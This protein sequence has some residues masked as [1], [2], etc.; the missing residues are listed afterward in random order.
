MS[1]IELF[2]SYA[3]EDQLLAKR[4]FDTLAAMPEVRIWM[5]KETLLPGEE[6]EQNIYEAI[7]RSRFFIVLLS[8]NWVRKDGFVKTE[9]QRLTELI[10]AAPSG[11]YTPIP[12]RL[13]PCFTDHPLLLR[14]QSVDMFPDWDRGALAIR[15]AIRK[16][17]D[18][19]TEAA[20]DQLVKGAYSPKAWTEEYA[21]HLLNLPSESVIELL[22]RKYNTLADD[23]FAVETL[24]QLAASAKSSMVSDYV[25]RTFEIVRMCGTEHELPSFYGSLLSCA[26]LL[27]KRLKPLFLRD[28]FNYRIEHLG[29][30]DRGSWWADLTLRDLAKHYICCESSWLLSHLTM[31]RQWHQK[32]LDVDQITVKK[33]LNQMEWD[34]AI[35]DLLVFYARRK[36]ETQILYTVLHLLRTSC[37]RAKG[38]GGLSSQRKLNFTA[39]PAGTQDSGWTREALRSDR[40]Q[41]A[42]DRAH[43]SRVGLLL[44]IAR[45]LAHSDPDYAAILWAE[46]L[47]GLEEVV[48][49]IA[50]RL[51][52]MS[53]SDLNA[54][55]DAI[56]RQDNH[57]IEFF[58]ESSK[59]QNLVRSF[60]CEG[61]HT[62]GPNSLPVSLPIEAFAGGDRALGSDLTLPL[63]R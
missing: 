19:D 30:V 57:A 39:P 11:R 8:T 59:D 27:S 6:W 22:D 21:G 38:S 37:D 1:Q 48:P 47:T 14:V 31:D 33:C 15:K 51:R 58:F 43:M 56:E 13:E 41:W 55:T 35:M 10:D 45:Y 60:V 16:R 26:S 32:K 62:R 9:L 54:L 5:D 2:I 12:V 53:P 36:N 17:I 44:R 18:N 28:V 3:S 42:D 63:F 29:S 34:I 49:A 46:G 7:A 4:L 25:F 50:D 61:A 23:L 24:A 52:L 40:I 20:F